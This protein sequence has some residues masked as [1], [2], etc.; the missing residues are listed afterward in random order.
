MPLILQIQTGSRAGQKVD[1]TKSVV[2]VGRHPD[3]DL[4]F[5]VNVDIDVSSRH[6]EF[7]GDENGW[8]ILDLG[9]TNGTWVN[10]ERIDTSKALRAGDTILLGA[11]GTR[12]EVLS[13]GSANDLAPPPTTRGGPTHKGRRRSTTERVAVAV[14]EQTG[15]LKKFVLAMSVLVVVGVGVI[16]ALNQKEADESRRA[17]ETLLHQSDSLR[18][19]LQQRVANADARAAGFDSIARELRT[20]R[21]RL[22]RELQAGGDVSHIT[23]QIGAL[24]RRTNKALSLTDKQIIEANGKAVA[25]IIVEARDRKFYGGSAFAVAP[26]LLVTNKHVLLEGG[27]PPVRIAVFFADTDAPVYAHFLSVA[28]DGDLGFLQ[29][30]KPGT[31]PTVRGVVSSANVAVGDPVI[32]I[33][34]PGTTDAAVGK[35][36]KTTSTYGRVSKIED[37]VVTINAYAAQGSS[38]SPVFDSRGLVVGVLVGGQGGDSSVITYFV[39]STKLIAALPPE[40]KGIVR[41]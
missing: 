37:T 11:K 15:H 6:A 1:L 26:G 10:G 12:I 18:S 22:T 39:P 4:R 3:A 36:K 21:D 30:D 31:H 29:L 8:S 13:T 9:S 41:Q 2:T 20:E 34:F 23:T 27:E 33:G 38:G 32:V 19:E 24:D 17:I 25:Y 14:A 40:A 5:D 35:V 28:S 7:R 16:I